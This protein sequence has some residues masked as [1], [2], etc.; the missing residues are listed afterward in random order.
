MINDQNPNNVRKKMS[1]F[2]YELILKADKTDVD[3]VNFLYCAAGEK[4]LGTNKLYAM[5]QCAKDI[6][7]C[8]GCL[9]WSI[10]ELSKCRYS[11]QGARV[12]GTICNV[13]V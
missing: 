10:R 12:L 7:D 8:K 6:L 4:N 11:K 3:G 1:D 5:V 9:A 2:L 13:K